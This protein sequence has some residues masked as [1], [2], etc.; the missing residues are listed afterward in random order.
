MF[1]NILE[2]QFL[3]NAFLAALLASIACG[4]IGSL[5]VEKRMV[6]MGGGIAHAA[7]GGIGLGFMLSFEPLYGGL[8]F[9]LIAAI[10]ITTIEQKSQSTPDLLISIC[11]S[12]GMALGILFIY[13]TP[14]Y[15][16]D[17]A[18]YL[19]GD[20]LTVS[21]NDLL[22]M[23]VL[24]ILI[25][26]IVLT[27]FQTLKSWLFD[28]SFTAVLGVPVKLL[29]YTLAILT[30]LTVV[31]LIKVTGVILV[32]SLLA[33]PAA[34]ARQFSNKLSVVMMISAF[35]GLVSSFMGLWL[36]WQFSIPSGATIVLTV[37]TIYLLSLLK[38]QK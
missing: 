3:Q 25:L 11:W 33:A 20:I 24:N 34:A 18:S 6:M 19:F 37:S 29:D 22:L 26:N 23:F 7:F 16:P 13:W 31:I 35:I 36:S 12:V 32:L 9:A 14:G 17:M 15:P 21:N 28:S 4:I 38:K 8:L 30:A 2:F 10:I 5:L 27:W 1:D